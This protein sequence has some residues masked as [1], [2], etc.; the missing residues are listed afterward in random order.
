MFS[1]I[2]YGNSLKDWL[3]SF[4]I[5]VGAI[6]LNFIIVLLNN[7]VFKKIAIRF[8]GKFNYIILEE[9]EAPVKLAVIMLAT[10]VAFGRLGFEQT[11]INFVNK[12]FRFL[13]VLNIT[14]VVVRFVGAFLENLLMPAAK[15]IHKRK[16][17]HEKLSAEQL[18][19]ITG[20]K[21]TEKSNPYFDEKLLPIIQRTINVIIWIIG[22]IMAL[23][24][25]GVDVAALLAG[26]GIGGL[27]FALASQDTLKNILGGIT[28]FTD[29]VFKIGERIKVDGFDGTVEDIGLRSTRIR[30]LEKRL[31][32]I[33]N[34][35]LVDYSIENITN[36]PMRRVLM[37][38]GLTYNTTHD[39]MQQA[40]EILR[41]MPNRIA[42]IDKNV[43]AVFTDY[44]TLSLD[45][46]FIYWVTT[47]GDTMETPSQV[48]MEILRSFNAAGLDF[49]FPTKVIY[50]E[51]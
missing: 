2:Y 14:W 8:P 19:K 7:K 28:I 30:T 51:K 16:K 17:K 36:E 29:H 41:D 3:I 43:T 11:T 50:L 21:I 48:N 22:I 26:L 23:V 47:S 35:K 12:S 40:L 39:K 25:V 15:E 20:K 31:V 49:A 6:I 4:A 13:I 42:H 38:I 27:A 34:Y 18:E 32:T 9:L 24:N 45:I 5:I 1:N 33:P 44:S 46:T 37:K 10:W